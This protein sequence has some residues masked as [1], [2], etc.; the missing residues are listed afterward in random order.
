MTNDPFGSVAE[1]DYLNSL[2][3]AFVGDADIIALDVALKLGRNRSI[4]VIY[5]L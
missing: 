3:A 2:V 4:P 1:V 5:K